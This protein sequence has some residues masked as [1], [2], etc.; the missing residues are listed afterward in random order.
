MEET[1]AVCLR[2]SAEEAVDGLQKGVWN[3][4]AVLPARCLWHWE[5][6]REEM[7]QSL[8]ELNVGK[9]ASGECQAVWF[10][11]YVVPKLGRCSNLA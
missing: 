3:F 6:I 10:C 8:T 1:I 4:P 9:T 2:R 5:A 11:F 7:Q